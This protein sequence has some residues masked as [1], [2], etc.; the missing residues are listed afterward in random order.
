MQP[1]VA[2]FLVLPLIILSAGPADA[3]RVEDVPAP[4]PGAW[5]V[6]TTG[7]L[8][9]EDLVALERLG[10]EVAAQT[11]AQLGVAVVGSTDGAPHRQF[12]T[13]LANRWGLGDREKDNG[14]LVFAALDDRAAEI[15]LGD[16]IDDAGHVTIALEIMHGDMVPRFRDGDPAAAIAAGAFA[17]ARRILGANPTVATAPLALAAPPATPSILPGT[18]AHPAANV[19]LAP[20]PVRHSVSPS[21]RLGSTTLFLLGLV[22][23]GGSL[24][25]LAGAHYYRRRRPRACGS[26][27]IE[28]VRL[29]EAEDDAHLSSGEQTEERLGSA[30]YDVWVCPTC[31]NT[32]K[33]RYGA[34]FTSYATCPRCN[35]RTVSTSHRTERQATTWSEGRV[36]IDEACQHCEYRHSETRLLPRIEEKDPSPDRDRSLSSSSRSLLSSSSSS[37]SSG[38]W[39]RSS[40]GS[41]SSSSSST[42]G[43]RSS[44]GGA[45]GRW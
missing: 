29:D 22:M 40:S 42:G 24:G 45:S 18:A 20:E 17:C 36:R 4:P 23:A 35:A 34:F 25:I 32:E 16:G 12:A 1:T 14:V 44:G 37:S 19:G 28:M 33:L 41:S 2:R 27:R 26:C 13:D 6:D 30:D 31:A 38:S 15:V 43:G 11:G 3:I 39:S 5:V 10:D 9:T 8:R 21:P 7:T